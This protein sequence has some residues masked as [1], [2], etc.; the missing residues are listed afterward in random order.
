MTKHKHY[1]CIV[2]WAE[3]AQI[4]YRNNSCCWTDVIGTPLWNLN[5]EYRIKKEAVI[6]TVYFKMESHPLIG[7]RYSEFKPD[8]ELWHLK[9]TYQDGKA[10]KAELPNEEK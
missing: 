9:I 4:E 1:D 5:N 3:G 10:V 8:M 7:T 2:A 6:E